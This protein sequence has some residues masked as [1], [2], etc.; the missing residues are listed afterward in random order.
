MTMAVQ[1]NH[2]IVNVRDKHVSARFYTEILGLDAAQPFGEWFLVVKLD[3][4]VSLDFCDDP[5]PISRQ[6][7][8]FLVSEAEFD[9]IFERIRARK[10]PYWADPAKQQPNQHNTHFGGRGVYWEDPDGHFLE[11]ITRPYEI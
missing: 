11:I 5:D 7:F 2:T 4:G 1:F 8:A 9:V 10:L 6:H 3:N